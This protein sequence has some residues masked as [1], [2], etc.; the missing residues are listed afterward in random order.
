MNTGERSIAGKI[1]WTVGKHLRRRQIL[2]DV[3]LHTT[4]HRPSTIWGEY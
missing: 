3:L 1:F 4:T 2:L